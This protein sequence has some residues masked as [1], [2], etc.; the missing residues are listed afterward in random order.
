MYFSY[1]LWKVWILIITGSFFKTA[2]AE[3]KTRGQKVVKKLLQEPQW[4]MM[5]SD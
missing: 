3:F 4:W 2:L 1:T 5:G